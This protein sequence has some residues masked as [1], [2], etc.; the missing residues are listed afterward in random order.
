MV[1]LQQVILLQYGSIFLKK[2]FLSYRIFRKV[3]QPHTERF[4]NVTWPDAVS[5]QYCHLID[6][7]NNKDNIFHM[8]I[9]VCN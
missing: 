5:K 8:S 1:Y 2:L 4:G 7:Y 6:L 9:T 3:V